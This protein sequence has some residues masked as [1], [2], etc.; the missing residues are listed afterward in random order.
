MAN[1]SANNVELPEDLSPVVTANQLH[2]AMQSMLAQINETVRV[3]LSRTQSMRPEISAQPSPVS[4][5]E[6]PT[7]LGQNSTDAAGMHLDRGSFEL[8]ESFFNEK[9]EQFII[10]RSTFFSIPP[11]TVIPA[12]VLDE[13][14]GLPLITPDHIHLMAKIRADCADKSSKEKPLSLL[15]EFPYI[16]STH[17]Y[18]EWIAENL[19]EL[20]S[21]FSHVTRMQWVALRQVV[22][23]IKALRSLV[24]ERFVVINELVCHGSLSASRV[25]AAIRHSDLGG[26]DQRLE[27]RVRSI[28]SKIQE[29]RL[30][31]REKLSLEAQFR[32]RTRVPFSNPVRGDRGRGRSDRGGRGGRGFSNEQAPVRLPAE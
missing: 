7:N 4:Q 5:Q 31:V 1:L 14:E 24:N 20:E 23:A 27:D 13:G 6:I 15:H 28:R 9:L 18:L 26:V 16:Y 19:L 3:S 17:A 11:A 10:P 8:Y 32:T 22:N 21:Q 12:S 2:S 29:T 30:S 25:E